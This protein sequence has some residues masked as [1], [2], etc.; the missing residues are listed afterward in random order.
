MS[1]LT[2]LSLFLTFGLVASAQV[3]TIPPPRVEIP[4]SESLQAVVVTTE[5]WSAVRGAAQLFER[6]NTKSNWRVV[7][8][9]FPVV[10]GKNGMAWSDGLNELPSDTGRLLMKTEGDGKSPAGIFSLTAAFGTTE[11]AGKFKLPY[12][13]LAASTECVD[14]VKS[15]H[16]NRIVD[17]YQVGIFD[18]KSSEKML[19]IGEQY[20]LGVFVEHNFEKQ[21]GAGS[22]IFLHIWKDANT[23][24]AGCTAMERKNIETV[25]AR[26]DSQKNPVLIQL[27]KDSYHQFQTKWKLPKRT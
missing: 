27:P 13:K 16:Y 21:K 10:V 5:N 4:Y 20:G 8:K 11:N 1:K 6:E 15:F 17:K 7:G 9:S 24:T 18:W 2:L 19:E 25:L 14:D 26:L 22:C 12:T 3:K 23:G